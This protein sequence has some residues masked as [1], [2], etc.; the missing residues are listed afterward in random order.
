MNNAYD[1]FESHAPV[2]AGN[3]IRRAILLPD[4]C[5]VLDRITST[6]PLDRPV[7]SRSVKR[8][9]S[10]RL[11]S[12]FEF[13]FES[14]LTGLII[15]FRTHEEYGS[16]GQP[17]LPPQSHVRDCLVSAFTSIPCA[18]HILFVKRHHVQ[19]LTGNPYRGR[20]DIA[21]NGKG[22][23]HSSRSINTS[24][25]S[26]EPRRAI[27]RLLEFRF[28]R[29]HAPRFDFPRPDSGRTP[30]VL[31]YVSHKIEKRRLGLEGSARLI[32]GTI[33]KGKR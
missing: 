17:R 14:L 28:N 16:N 4:W 29:H 21:G 32:I 18:I 27:G 31:V 30:P 20:V 1:E 25:S 26:D 12:S 10:D 2:H 15:T 6:R 23:R 5:Y 33:S 9:R 24:E 7:K 11:F 3:S 19:P 13:R 8:R 22:P